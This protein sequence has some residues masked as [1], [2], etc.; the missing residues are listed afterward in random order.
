M[1]SLKKLLYVPVVLSI[2]LATSSSVFADTATSHHVLHHSVN[3]STLT[4]TQIDKLVT[5][6]Q[7]RFTS[8]VKGLPQQT[9]I[10]SGGQANIPFTYQ[11]H[12]DIQLILKNTGKQTIDYEIN[13]PDDTRNLMKSS[14]APGQQQQWNL[15]LYDVY[16]QAS[17]GLW[18]IFAVT[19]DGS[20]GKLKVQASVVND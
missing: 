16:R 15:P 19:T 1:K 6:Q 20:T 8:K 11:N 5:Y 18:N 13:F 3:R 12:A 14:L 17:W 7:T 4:H 9:F 10:L 2:P